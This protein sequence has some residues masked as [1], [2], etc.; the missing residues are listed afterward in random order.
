MNKW[1]LNIFVPDA[2]FIFVHKYV[3]TCLV[4]SGLG[5]TNQHF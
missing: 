5:N 1:V 2:I 3:C 4:F